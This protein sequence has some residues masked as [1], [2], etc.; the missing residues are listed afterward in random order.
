[1]STQKQTGKI[2][3]VEGQYFLETADPNNAK[4]QLMV[5]LSSIA[6]QEKLEPAAGKQVTVVLSEPQRYIV[7]I[8]AS[9]TILKRKRILCYVPAPQ[10]LTTLTVDPA[11]AKSIAKNLLDQKAISQATFNQIVE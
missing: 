1:M 4:K 2:V 11:M 7:A 9:D 6:D 10:W 5:P 8:D 3:A